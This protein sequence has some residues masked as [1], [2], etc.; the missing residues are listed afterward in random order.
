MASF[1][2]FFISSSPNYTTIKLLTT[3]SILYCQTKST[4][5]PDHQ[6][7]TNK[8]LLIDWLIDM[9]YLIYIIIIIIDYCSCDEVIYMIFTN[10]KRKK[11]TY[12]SRDFNNIY[13]NYYIYMI[14]WLCLQNSWSK[15]VFW[16]WIYFSWIIIFYLI[17]CCIQ[18]WTIITIIIIIMNNSD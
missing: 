14:S 5:P 1:F 7:T 9:F 2:F 3:N 4:K 12:S 16:L 6:A 15:S 13:I 17:S 18:D 11:L 8:K 10:E